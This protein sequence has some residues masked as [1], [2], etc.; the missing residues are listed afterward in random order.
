MDTTRNIL[1]HHEL[2]LGPDYVDYDRRITYSTLAKQALKSR[3]TNETLSEEMRI[4]Y[5]ALTRARERLIITG[6]VKDLDKEIKTGNTPL[7]LRIR[8]CQSIK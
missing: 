3:I 8:N 6:A 7:L 2:G 1:F 5:V 4:L